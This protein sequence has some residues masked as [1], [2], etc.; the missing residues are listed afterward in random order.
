MKEFLEGSMAVAKA[1]ALCKPGVVSAYPITPQT[2]IV[3]ELA[4]MVADGHLNSQFVNV[5]SEHSA[6]SVVLGAQATG[7]RS[8]TATS[9]QGLF[10]MAEVVFNIAGMRLPIVMTDANRAISAPINIWNDQ[11]DTIS[12][13]DSGWVQ[14]YMEDLQETVDFHIMA[15]RLGEDRSIMLPVMVCMDGF[16]LTHGIETV[17]M[18]SQEQVDKFLPPYKALYKL[19]VEDPMTLGPL[20]DPDY[21][22]E[23]R[24]A[25]HA[26]HKKVLDLLPKITAEYAKATGR[27]YNGLIEGYQIKDAERVI[28]AMG[29]VCGTV[30]D[31]VDELRAK[32]K[33]V[34]LLKITCFRPF[35]AEQICDALKNT[36][37]VGILD[38]SVS[39]GSYAPLAAEM[40]AAFFGKKKK[41]EIISSFVA[42]LGGRDITKES[43]KEMFSMLT[44]KEKACEYIDLKPELLKE[45]YE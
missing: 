13:R 44:Q 9:S 16:I 40:K 7:V 39:L 2:H 43:V 45:N 19:D 35:P 1:V 27:Q 28:V 38:K 31:V 12:L 22:M 15:Y 41:P 26:T 3:E 23:T 17:D 14:L 34:G 11:Q 4:Q 18:P 21:Y 36:A 30:K 33:K 37:R 29:S 8:Y 5:E 24:Y 32:G 42:G 20:A 10:L 6:A 25:I